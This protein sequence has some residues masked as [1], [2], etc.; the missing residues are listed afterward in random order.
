[1]TISIFRDGILQFT[2]EII[3]A[4]ES[5]TRSLTGV[6]ISDQWQMSL[7]YDEAEKIKREYGIPAKGTTDKTPGGIELAHISEVIRPVLG[8]FLNE[9][10]R[11][12]D[13]YRDHFQDAGISKV[14]LS[15]GGAKMKGIEKFLSDGLNLPVETINPL[16]GIYFDPQQVDTIFVR[17]A[18]LRLAAAISLASG[19]A[20]TI[21]FYK[22]KAASALS[23][24]DFGPLNEYLQKIQI[25]QAGWVGAAVVV[26]LLTF[27][28]YW[29]LEA[30]IGRYREEVASKK[31]IMNDLKSLAQR[32]EVIEQIKALRTDI[33]STL[34]KLT[35]IIPQGV[36]FTTLDYDNSTKAFASNGTATQPTNVG[37]FLKNLEDSP[38]FSGPVL[39]NIKRAGEDGAANM[40]YEMGFKTQ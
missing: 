11:S 21:N 25:S 26:V 30:T 7:T 27:L 39:K 19:K 34:F 1:T 3:I 12:F 32:R 10:S 6:L 33:R 17:D 20:G 24:I 14:I 22:T 8:Q 2:R 35:E 13:Y 38:Y 29:N 31:T 5:I 15:G 28:Y 40:T 23:Q 16:Q 37:T 9:I 36:F 18:A 4:G